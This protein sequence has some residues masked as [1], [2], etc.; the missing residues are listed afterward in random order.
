MTNPRKQAASSGGRVGECT[1]SPG[2]GHGWRPLAQAGTV[3][4]GEWPTSSAFSGGH[5]ARGGTPGR[6][7]ALPGPDG[8]LA[9]KRCP[10]AQLAKR[11]SL[12]RAAAL[13]APCRDRTRACPETGDAM[14]AVGGSPDLPVRLPLT[15]S[16]GRIS[17]RISDTKPLTRGEKKDGAANIASEPAPPGRPARRR[18]L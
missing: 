15:R 12:S 1:A 7:L 13:P 11:R 18:R 14:E 16:R 10:N 17:G 3:Q 6:G 5:G 9:K 8:E 2:V 4:R